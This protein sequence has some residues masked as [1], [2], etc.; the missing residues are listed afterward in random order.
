MKNNKKQDNKRT[1]FLLAK[2]IIKFDLYHGIIWRFE[3]IKAFIPT[4]LYL[5]YNRDLV[6]KHSNAAAA[7]TV[8]RHLSAV[9]FMKLRHPQPLTPHSRSL[10][11]EI[12]LSGVPQQNRCST[13]E[14]DSES[15]KSDYREGKLDSDVKRLKPRRGSVACV[16]GARSRSAAVG[17]GGGGGEEEEQRLVPPPVVAS[18][19]RRAWFLTRYSAP[20]QDDTSAGNMASY[21]QVRPRTPLLPLTTCPLCRGVAV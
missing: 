6:Y 20:E 15:G 21:L 14:L 1:S 11:L 10:S 3:W 2:P 19:P 12:G 13:F 18:S 16:A 17:E 7:F 8:R 9:I 4:R 5:M